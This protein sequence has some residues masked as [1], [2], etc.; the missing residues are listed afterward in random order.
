MKKLVALL[1]VLMLAACIVP[2][3]AEEEAKYPEVVEGMDFGGAT[4]I[5]NPYWEQP[6]RVENPDEDQQAT[7]DYQDWIQ[8]TYHV[9]IKYEQLGSWGDPQVTEVRNIVS[10][11]D[12]DTYRV[13]LMPPGFVGNP[14]A[15]GWFA[16]WSQNQ[17]IDVKGEK[18]NA[19]IVDF[20]TKAGAVYGVAYGAPEPRQ[21][22]YFNKKLL[23][24]AEIDWNEIYDLQKEGNWT[25]DKLE[26]Y[27][28]QLTKDTNAD[29]VPDVYGI[30]G[31]VNDLYMAAVFG[32]NGSFFDFDESGKLVVTAG[33]EN[34]QEAL[35]WAANLWNNYARKQ[36]WEG[37]EPWDF[38]INTFKSGNCAFMV[39]QTYG[40]YN[41]NAELA[42]MQ[43]DWGCVMIPKGPKGD[44]YKF[45][46]SE[47]VVVI[48]AIYDKET[49]DKIQFIYDLW[50]TTAPGVDETTAWIGSKYD[51]CSDTRA[52]D[53]TYALMREPQS[54]AA[55]KSLYL[56]D[57]NTVLGTQ[58]HGNFLWGMLGGNPQELMEGVMPFWNSLLDDFNNPAQ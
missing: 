5:I 10:N 54:A 38:F 25:W 19:G 20:M 13:I 3:M 37:G 4:L 26:E 39:H 21:C 28:K 58:D 17:Y 49:T 9:T 50:S 1:L 22:L 55:D 46:V 23:K 7:Y 44:N 15:N 11:A 2:S 47:N 56:G 16:D 8:E 14:M 6:G 27:C 31:N 30:T 42:D 35:I 43:D 33:S 24:D 53:E 32:N 18:Y 40:G 12:K 51:I 57:N 45:L 29:G 41:D 36:D 52:V 48:P 34:T